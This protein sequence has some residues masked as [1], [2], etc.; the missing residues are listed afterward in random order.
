MTLWSDRAV[1]DRCFELQKIGVAFPR[2]PGAR[3]GRGFADV[4]YEEFGLLPS[5]RVVSLLTGAVREF[6]ENEQRFFFVVPTVDEVREEIDRRGWDIV[7]L[8]SPER[9]DWFLEA[10]SE[11]AAQT[12]AVHAPT[13]LETFLQALI[14]IQKTNGPT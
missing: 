2:V 14:E 13:L 5:A 10:R 1:L 7:Q 11:G 4:G 6:A 12:I 9:R 8:E 3:I